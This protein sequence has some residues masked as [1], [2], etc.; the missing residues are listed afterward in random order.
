MPSS[1]PYDPSLVMGLHA[2]AP[3]NVEEADKDAVQQT[4]N[5]E[6]DK[7]PTSSDSG[8]SISEID[9]L[10]PNSEQEKPDN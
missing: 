6:H 10:M 7:K 4:E 3:K 8:H 5:E 1:I 2:V 9:Q